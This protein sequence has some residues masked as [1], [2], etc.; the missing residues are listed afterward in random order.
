VISGEVAGV[1][2]VMALAKE[3]GVRRAVRLNVSG[4]FHSPLMAVALPGLEQALDDA[5]L[6]DPRSR[7]TRT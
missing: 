5:A 6:A 7:S 4:A 2:R 1:E 3:A